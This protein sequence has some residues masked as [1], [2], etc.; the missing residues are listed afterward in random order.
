MHAKA[1]DYKVVLSNSQENNKKNIKKY[2]EV[3]N[4]SIR[5]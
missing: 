1:S 4:I 5:S 2:C 3:E